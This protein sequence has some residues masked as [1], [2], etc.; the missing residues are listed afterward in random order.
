MAR[1]KRFI[2]DPF[3][4][5]V[6]FRSHGSFDIHT[7]YEQQQ[8]AAAATKR[9]QTSRARQFLPQSLSKLEQMMKKK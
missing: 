4:S 9:K 3:T 1:V 7:V 6:G 2:T 5:A 8:Q